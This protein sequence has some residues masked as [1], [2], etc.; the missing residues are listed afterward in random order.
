MTAALLGR[1]SASACCARSVLAIPLVWL[2]NIEG[3]ADLAYANF[4]T[5]RDRVDPVDLGVA[6]YLA[7]I[8][9]P[10]ML[11][12]HVMIFVYLL[13]PRAKA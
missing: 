5:F 2:F 13:R 9:V 12:T 3:F 10:A 4:S 7:A 8:N 11:V 6:Y 1:L